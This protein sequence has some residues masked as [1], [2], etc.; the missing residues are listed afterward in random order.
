MMKQLFRRQLAAGNVVVPLFGALA[1][2]FDFLTD[3][4]NAAQVLPF[5]PPTQPGSIVARVRRPDFN[6]LA[7]LFH[8]PLLVH[9]STKLVILDVFGNF[10]FQ[11]ALIRLNIQQILRFSCY[12]SFCRLLLTIQRIRDNPLA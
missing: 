1:V 9:A 2:S 8:R 7:V 11:I 10:F 3:C 5:L 6:P 4:A 12:D